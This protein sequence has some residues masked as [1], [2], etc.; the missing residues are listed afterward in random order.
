MYPLV[1]LLCAGVSSLLCHRCSSSHTCYK[2]CWCVLLFSWIMSQCQ[3]HTLPWN[4]HRPLTH[5]RPS[6]H[7]ICNLI[8]DWDP[9]HLI[10]TGHTQLNQRPFCFITQVSNNKNKRLPQDKKLQVK[11]QR[12]GVSFWPKFIYCFI[13]SW[14]DTAARWDF[15]YGFSATCDTFCMVKIR[16]HQRA[17]HFYLIVILFFF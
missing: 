5:W 16:H 12:S 2:L 13:A 14:N 1:S 17:A 6:V 11:G 8:T 9:I 3:H 15:G 7:W 4:C 10:V